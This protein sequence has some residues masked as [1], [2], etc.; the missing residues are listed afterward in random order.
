MI[1]KLSKIERRE[2]DMMRMMGVVTVGVLLSLFLLTP[3]Q[4][5]SIGIGAFPADAT[6]L[7]F[8]NLNPGS[9]VSNQYIG[10]GA[11]FSGAN[12]VVNLGSPGG[13]PLTNNVLSVTGSMTVAFTGVN[14]DMVGLNIAL[15]GTTPVYLEAYNAQ[16][17]LL[18]TISALSGFLGLSTAEMIAYVII[19]D[20]GGTFTID[21][22]TYADPPGVGVPEPSTLVFLG[23]GLLGLGLLA[24]RRF[25]TKS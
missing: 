12:L 15:N 5:D 14:V 17:V 7:N 19:H 1:V 23:S 20:S 24:R 25:R 8:E 9:W 10:Q 6:I 18:G 16:G 21:N 3:A 4:A 11:V 22:F 13:V 2:K